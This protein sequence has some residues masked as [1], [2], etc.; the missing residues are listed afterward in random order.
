MSVE[1]RLPEGFFEL[2]R[3]LPREGPG[4]PE[5]VLWTLEATG[6]SGA[7]RV[8]DA[9]CGPGAD[10]ETLARA[11]P[12]AEVE[13]VD[14]VAGFAEEARA[15]VA[16]FGRRASAR[17]G[18]MAALE[19]SYDLIWCAGALYFLGLEQGLR[20]WR[21]ALA[22]GGWIAFSEPCYLSD[23]P[24]EDARAFW[25]GEAE[26]PTLD[27]LRSRVAAAG[28]VLQGERMIA[29][30]AW[31]AYYDPLEARADALEAQGRAAR[32]V[33]DARREIALWR[34]AREE[35]AYALLLV[36]PA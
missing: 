11:L 9:G 29:G 6:L 4:R 23:D 24:S 15:R 33:A 25:Q 2:H 12:E 10:L 5:D 8:L 34:A 3:G 36:Q 7:V 13:G 22:P 28:Y 30:A 17:H 21:D 14:M 18:D 26:V 19:G 27:G 16:W 35:I 1:A 32:A 20:L 31:Q